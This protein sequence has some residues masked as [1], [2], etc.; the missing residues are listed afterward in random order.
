M[1]NCRMLCTD[2]LHRSDPPK[3]KVYYASAN[4][5][6]ALLTSIFTVNQLMVAHIQWRHDEMI[7][8]R[9]QGHAELDRLSGWTIKV[10]EASSVGLNIRNSHA[11]H[12]TAKNVS[13]CIKRSTCSS[14][15]LQEKNYA[16]HTKP[17][18]G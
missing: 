16:T 10:L 8:G 15:L 9:E 1:P 7:W 13:V 2:F 17:Q 3:E 12:L 14:W 11:S 5:R 4:P 6:Q 18:V